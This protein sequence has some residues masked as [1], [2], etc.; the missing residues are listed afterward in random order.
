MKFKCPKCEFIMEAPD[1]WAG[2]ESQCPKCAQRLRVPGT[3]K[4][5]GHVL[6][7]YDCRQMFPAE[8]TTA[9]EVN[10]GRSEGG[11]FGVGGGGLWGGLSKNAHYA[12]VDLCPPCA[13]HRAMID[14]NAAICTA[15]AGTAAV[16][17]VGAG[18][19]AESFT[20]FGVTFFLGVIAL[21]VAT[22]ILPTKVTR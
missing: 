17:S 5:S 11:M 14:R 20:A 1:H 4:P 8:Q 18:I 21:A 2:R 6:Q 15:I 16:V 22:A 13:A 10:V 19:I 7:C 3:P 12:K 9:R